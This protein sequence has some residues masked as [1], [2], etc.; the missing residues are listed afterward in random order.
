MTYWDAKPL[1]QDYNG[2]DTEFFTRGHLAKALN[3]ESVSIRALERRG[4][5]CHPRLKNGRGWW[6]YTW[7]QIEDLIQLAR[8]EKVLNPNYRR[9]FTQRFIDEA[10]QIL[11]R[12]PE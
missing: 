6:L 12:L 10:W 4:V 1:S 9:P 3:R 7:D 8:E 11:N 5:L 2:R